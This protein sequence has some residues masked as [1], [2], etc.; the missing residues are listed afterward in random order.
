MSIYQKWYCIAWK[1]TIPVRMVALREVV[2][3]ALALSPGKY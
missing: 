2:G 3:R 1:A